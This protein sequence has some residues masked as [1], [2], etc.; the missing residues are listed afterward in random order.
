M[1]KNKLERYEKQYRVEIDSL[2]EFGKTDDEI[3]RFIV[4]TE[5]KL[6]FQ[7]VENLIKVLQ[8]SPDS[9]SNIKALMDYRSLRTLQISYRDILYDYNHGINPEVGQL[10]IDTMQIEFQELEKKRRDMHNKALGNFCGLMRTYRQLN[11]PPFHIGEYMD[12]HYEEN[13]YGDPNIRRDMTDSMFSL[14]NAIEDVNIIELQKRM[15]QN[16]EAVQVVDEMRKKLNTETKSYKIRF[17]SDE[18]DVERI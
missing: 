9:L 10:K 7:K 5:R 12:P 16:K 14:L 8:K 13:E 1:G 18:D 3:Y 4:N 11:I 15:E 2:R 17:N 6:Q